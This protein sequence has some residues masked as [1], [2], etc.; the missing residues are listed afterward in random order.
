MAVLYTA[1]RNRKTHSQGIEWMREP[2]DSG[3]MGSV[4]RHDG[5][6]RAVFTLNTGE[7]DADTIT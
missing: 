1:E 4:R 7:Y 3:I 5:V 2:E 6:G